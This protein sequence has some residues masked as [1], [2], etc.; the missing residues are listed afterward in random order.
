MAE[1]GFLL[2]GSFLSAPSYR[3]ALMLRLC[4]LRFDYRH[5][6]LA[7][8]EHKSPE[9]RA[10]NRFGQVPALRHDG[11]VYVQS[12]AILQHLAA[13]ADRYRGA[14]PEERIAIAETM[15]WE[16]DRLYPG[17]TRLR[18]FRR[19]LRAEPAVQDWFEGF[20]TNGLAVLDELLDGRDWLVGSAPTIADISCYAPVAQMD[21]AGLKEADWPNIAA[22]TARMR[23]LPGYAAPYDLLP[24]HSAE[25]L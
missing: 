8:G 5:V 12:N 6:D 18:F 17:L 23:A 13:H 25:G 3:V 21:E 7:A 10:I 15:C 11:R 2:Y 19:F 24:Q 16:A 14:D 22:W 4:G 20:A 1:D 9:F